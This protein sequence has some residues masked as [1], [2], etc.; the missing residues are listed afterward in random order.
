MVINLID[1]TGS[2][3]LTETDGGRANVKDRHGAQGRAR[4]HEG[5]KAQGD[6]C[7]TDKDWIRMRSS[8]E[9]ADICKCVGCVSCLGAVGAVGAV[10]ELLALLG[11]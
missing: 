5:T 1:S 8:G 7:V 9:A 11:D 10:L 2:E 3:F 6:G 4:R